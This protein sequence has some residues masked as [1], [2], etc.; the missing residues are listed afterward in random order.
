MHPTPP[1]GYAVL[2]RLG[3]TFSGFVVRHKDRL[4]GICNMYV[5]LETEPLRFHD[6]TGKLTELDPRSM[7]LQ[8]TVQI[9]NVC[10]ETNAIAFLDYEPVFTLNS[11]DE[12]LVLRSMGTPLNGKI[13]GGES[14]QSGSYNSNDGARR[15]EIQTDEPLAIEGARG[16]P[17]ILKSTNKVI[18]VITRG[19]DRASNLAEFKSLCIDS[20]I[21]PNLPLGNELEKAAAL[22]KHASGWQSYGHALSTPVS[23]FNMLPLDKHTAAA[24]CFVGGWTQGFTNPGQL[25]SSAVSLLEFSD[26]DLVKSLPSAIARSYNLAARRPGPG[27]IQAQSIHPLIGFRCDASS[28]VRADEPADIKT[29]AWAARGNR[30]VEVVLSGIDMSDPELSQVIE[31]AFKAAEMVNPP[32]K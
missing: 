21:E 11:N 5:L 14:F 22:L 2:T 15:F 8:G 17:V 28:I 7:R 19:T 20:T 31:A 27:D 3:S 32:Q 30:L 1:N 16:C 23:W 4:L 25:E 18:G 26:R 29:F 12:V 10:N 13:R 6:R 9:F 24:E